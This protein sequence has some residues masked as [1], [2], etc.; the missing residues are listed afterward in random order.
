VIAWSQNTPISK[1]LI[2]RLKDTQA[3]NL[4]QVIMDLKLSDKKKSHK[5]FFVPNPY[6]PSFRKK[7][8]PRDN[9]INAKGIRDFKK[10]L[11]KVRFFHQKKVHEWAKW[12][13]VEEREYCLC[14]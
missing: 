2:E 10:S 1:E 6:Y 13:S 11:K 8:E 14:F 9:P 4:K 7:M 3:V 12:M 5:G